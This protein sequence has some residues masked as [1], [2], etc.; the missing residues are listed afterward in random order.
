MRCIYC[1][2]LICYLLNI[3]GGNVRGDIPHEHLYVCFRGGG[4]GGPSIEQMFGREIT[5]EYCPSE[6]GCLDPYIHVY[7]ANINH[8]IIYKDRP[9]GK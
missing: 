7:V 9:N 3:L 5:G 4:G 8:N 2:I 1:N 6:G